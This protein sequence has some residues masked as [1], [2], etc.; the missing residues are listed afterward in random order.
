MNLKTLSVV[1][2]ALLISSVAHAKVGDPTGDLI[3]RPRQNSLVASAPKNLDHA[4]AVR[5]LGDGIK[6]HLA[7]PDIYLVRPTRGQNWSTLRRQLLSTGMY[8]F[9]VPDTVAGP[10]SLPNDPEFVNQWHLTQ[11]SATR[12]WDFNTGINTNTST[13]VVVASVDG[14]VDLTHPDLTGNFASGY[15]TLT[16]LAQ[17]AGGIVTDVRSNGHGTRIAGVIAAKGN[18]GIGVTGIGW[19][20]K[21]MPIRCTDDA[22]FGTT[23]RS[24][25]L[26]GAQWAI[27]NG[28][29]AV[30]I[31]YT[32][33][34]YPDVEAM[35]Q[36][37]WDHNADLVWAAGN[38]NSN[39]N[40]FDHPHVIVVGGTDQSDNRWVS[41]GTVGSGY[42]RAVDIF[43]PCILIK[44]T[45]KG[46][47]YGYAPVGT[48]FAAPQVAATLG[49]LRAQNPGWTSQITEWRLLR[50][51]RDLGPLGADTTYGW[52]RL[53]L[54]RALDFPATYYDLTM[55]PRVT[56]WAQ[57]EEAQGINDLGRIVSKMST[58]GGAQSIVWYDN[59]A[60]AGATDFSLHPGGFPGTD[61]NIF[62]LNSMNTVVGSIFGSGEWAFIYKIG[63]GWINTPHPM[64]WPYDGAY[65]I[66][67]NDVVAGVDWEPSPQIRGWLKPL[68]GSASV[69]IPSSNNYISAVNDSLQYAGSYNWTYD[70]PFV[71]DGQTVISLPHNI[72]PSSIPV[73]ISNRGEVYGNESNNSGFVAPVIH[74][75]PYTV[76]SYRNIGAANTQVFD[77]NDNGIAVGIDRT[78]NK[79]VT[80]ETFFNGGTVIQDR[81]NTLLPPNIQRLETARAINNKG[82]IVGGARGFDGK[83]YPYV[84]RPTD[85]PTALIN[86]GQLGASPTYIGSIP[87]TLN[88]T[89]TDPLGSPYPGATTQLN[90]SG[91][92]GQVL[93]RLPASVTGQFRMY[94]R[95]N[96]TAVPGYVGPSFL[97]RLYPPIGTPAAA[98]DVAYLPFSGPPSPL[99]GQPTL[100]MYAGD[101]DDSNEVDAV[102][103]DIVIANFGF[104]D[105]QPGFNP[106]IDVDGT[107]E[108]DA[109]DIDLV[110]ANFGLVGDPEP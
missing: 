23:T 48:S 18:N 6:M 57:T 12:A 45:S 108:I 25:L 21:V 68:S 106:A 101:V 26:E 95:C 105:G 34:Q 73:S 84:A 91:T 35:G 92:S 31:S 82:E 85:G 51:S 94:M 39:W 29:Q 54:G 100:E 64:G 72:A 87:P 3:V 61:F 74:Q 33:V 47:G 59:D 44:T 58:T 1:T 90:Y 65:A 60:V 41:S 76:A 67:S 71:F 53:N 63:V 80:W 81:L 38:T 15:N 102:D 89:F 70:S 79:A 88:V 22:A 19:N 75:P 10:C 20:L 69:P 97:P 83:M 8:E 28:A 9:V 11:I 50:A 104:V 86:L 66:N 107:G 56:T 103:I 30:T 27:D 42:G 55:L 77:A 78:T 36:Y 62:G 99:T 2:L 24:E 7:G 4:A 52:G 32:E 93:I 17:S 98:P 13:S 14:G 49:L 37:A 40:S 16:G 46:G 96:S 109:A 43:A 110:I 5:L